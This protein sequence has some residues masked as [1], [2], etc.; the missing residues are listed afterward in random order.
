[1]ITLMAEEIKRWLVE[2]AMLYAFAILL[3]VTVLFTAA[4]F[5][6]MYA[7]YHGPRTVLCPETGAP[8]VV[9]LDALHAALGSLRDEPKIRLVACSRWDE[10]GQCDQPC[11]KQLRP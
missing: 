9:H 1:M 10:R 2:M 7:R 5:G 6:R 11:V 4:W 8:A 3:G